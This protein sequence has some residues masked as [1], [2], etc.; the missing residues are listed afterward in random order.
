MRSSRVLRLRVTLMRSCQL[1]RQTTPNIAT[2][3]SAP[4]PHLDANQLALFQQLTQTAKAG[5]AVPTQPVTVPVSLVPSSTTANVPPVAPP[6]G[7]P[8]QSLPY[9][10]D[11]FGPGRRD[12]KYDR[13][14]GPE[15][16]RDRDEYH[17][18]R[19]DFK[20][21]YRGG[22]RGRGRGRGRWDDRDRYKDNR[23]RD[24]NAAQRN[25][26][27][28][29]R[30]PPRNRFGG[31]RREVRPYSPPRRPS[32]S[33]TSG[34][35]LQRDGPPS[36]VDSGK[37]EFG[38]DLR[39][40]SPEESTPPSQSHTAAALSPPPPSSAPGPLAE[41]TQEKEKVPRDT[42]QITSSIPQ[43]TTD[44]LPR[45]DSAEPNPGL[46]TFD[47]TSFNPTDPSSW[48]ALGKAWTVSRGTMPSQE[49]LMQYVMSGGAMGMFS[50]SMAGQYDAEQGE[51]WGAGQ[52]QD[53][54]PAQQWNER[55]RGRGGLHRGNG[56][57][58]NWGYSGGRGY[59]QRD[60]D[61]ITLGGGDDQE[62]YEL[63]YGE[64]SSW[65]DFSMQNGNAE[66]QQA[67]GEQS[68]SVG[69]TGGGRAGR[70]Q[71]VGD[72]WVFVRADATIASEAA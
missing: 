47:M 48:E 27:S 4:A 68:E 29:S 53:W 3:A 10:D 57:G 9:R 49:E 63:A 37:D 64:D 55:G 44:V 72:K 71:R 66:Q 39:P 69:S 59:G 42:S 20:G 8:S 25:R 54:E 6:V 32:L 26:R 16:G 45:M 61:A 65:Q 2:L 11:H 41:D 58:S 21:E 35:P 28:R 19:R 67:P 31:A 12:P 30:S 62:S 1:T 56:R 34:S 18:E 43:A 33:L 52:D 15:R 50:T 7:G 17:D 40:Q 24:W 13:F 14:N 36:S 70:M 23:E 60:T 22:Q 51:Q 38:R 5:G 46:D